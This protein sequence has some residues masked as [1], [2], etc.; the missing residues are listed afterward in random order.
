M[1]VIAESKDS[2]IPQKGSDMKFNEKQNK[3]NMQVGIFVVIGLIILIFA[4]A[5]LTDTLKKGDL[6]N[7][8]IS[9]PSAIGLEVGDGVL[10]LGINQGKVTRLSIDGNKV[11]ADLAVKL[12]E[13]LKEGTQFIIKN[14]SL[15][16]S[17]RVVIIPGTGSK[18]LDTSRIITGEVESGI[19]ELAGGAGIVLSEFSSLLKALNSEEG[20]IRKYAQ[21]ADSLQSSVAGINNFISDNTENLSITA[22]N[23]ANSSTEMAKLI[24]DNMAQIDSTIAGADSLMQNLNRAGRSINILA[25]EIILISQQLNNRNSTFSE[26]TGDDELYQKL[27]SSTAALD[28]LLKDIKEN[29]KKYLTVKIF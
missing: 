15:M 22:E 21:L 2:C 27:L 29:P 3:N 5:W 11:I 12:T 16:G 24:N 25:Q 10:I 6:T 8:K 4:W 13:P 26:L 20:M 28:S 18:L 1:P 7:L 17:T 9:F 19:T 14:T 23:L